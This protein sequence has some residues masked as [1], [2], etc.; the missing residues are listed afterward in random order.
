[1]ANPEKPYNPL[2]K[3]NLAGSVAKA[4]L[5]QPVVALAELEKFEGAGIYA[6]Y[7]RGEHPAYEALASLTRRQGYVVPIYV[8]KAVPKGSR[9]GTSLELEHGTV[10]YDRLCEHR[11]SIELA[12]NLEVSHFWLRYLVI[13]EIWIPLGESL[14]IARYSPVWNVV[15]DGFGNHNPGK[16]R[17]AGMRS[18]WDVLHPGRTW[19]ES[20]RARQESKEVILS[21]V[22]QHLLDKLIEDSDVWP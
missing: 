5:S 3:I 13:D 1:M 4:L 17:Y 8:G 12:T 22:R 20:C 19:A 15:V 14:L 7:Y 11:K 6:L 21:E 9:K 10:L 2:D 18:R 16:G